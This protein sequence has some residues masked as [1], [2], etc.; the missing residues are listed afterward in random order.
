MKGLVSVII[1]VYNRESLLE[2]CINSVIL[3]SYKNF[4]IILVDD[5]STDSTVNICRNL[6]EKDSRIK[7]FE[8]DHG[9]V[10]AARNLALEKAQGEYVFFLDSDDVIHPL[11]FESLVSGM[12]ETGAQI[13]G[14]SVNFIFE[15]EWFRATEEIRNPAQVSAYK[16]KQHALAVKALFT[17]SSPINLVGGVIMRRDFV[18]DTRFKTDL[19]IGEDYFF[20]YENLIKG[21]DC[22]FLKE[23]WYYARIHSSNSSYSLSFNAFWSRFHRR[24][25]V[26]KNEEA[27][28]RR[29]YADIQKRDAFACYTTCLKRI[30]IHSNDFK[31]MQKKMKEYKKEL[32]T[33]FNIKYKVLYYLSVFTPSIYLKIKK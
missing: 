20:I 27:L 32:F 12:E 22:V 5:G 2:E 10:S 30:K 18:A 6:C 25:L 14:T 16:F 9:G 33:A 15:N 4:E 24:E 1:P 26:W 13:G 17:A 7:L 28:G 29:E 3:Q 19:F 23:N 21:A 31:K 11:L 8:A